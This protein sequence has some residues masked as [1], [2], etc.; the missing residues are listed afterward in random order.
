[1][2]LPRPTEKELEKWNKSDYFTRI[3]QSDV[4]KKLKIDQYELTEWIHR[5]YESVI[6]TGNE[7]NY[8]DYKKISK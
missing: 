2:T 8:K 3:L 5:N 4:D 7:L 6:H 1:M